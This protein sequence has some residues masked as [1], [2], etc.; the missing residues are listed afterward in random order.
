VISY[1]PG[2]QSAVKDLKESTKQRFVGIDFGYPAPLVEAEIVARESGVDVAMAGTLVELGQRSR[3]LRGQGLE[4]GA[5]TRMLIHAGR[6][7]LAGLDLIK[8]ARA[9]LVLPLTDDAE[10]REA[11]DAAIAACLE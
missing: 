5:S 8:A 2:Y 10:L 4:E 3:N 6:L 9:A 1:N 11:L 7:V